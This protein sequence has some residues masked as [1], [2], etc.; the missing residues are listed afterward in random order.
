M[1]T[2][3]GKLTDNIVK[4]IR[5]RITHSDADPDTLELDLE[6]PRGYVAKIKEV[7]FE[8]IQPGDNLALADSYALNLALIRDPDDAATVLVPANEVQHDVIFS[9]TMWVSVIA[10]E[11]ALASRVRRSKRF[12][13]EEDSFT[14]R[15][16]RFNT[17]SDGVDS[18]VSYSDCYVYYT[19]E[20]VTT[21]E[22]LEL[23]DIL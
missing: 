17:D 3:M 14:A 20:T 21:G 15:N 16:L 18:N 13:Q 8:H 6:L 1:E 7:I 22:I 2:L 5:G 9:T 19:L 10:T 4:V 11:S 23:L 12:D